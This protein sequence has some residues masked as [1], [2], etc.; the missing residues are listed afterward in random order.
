MSNVDGKCLG[1]IKA[2]TLAQYIAALL[3]ILLHSGRFLEHAESNFFIK[4]IICR[5]AVPLFMVITSYFYRLNHQKS[6]TYSRDYF[7]RQ[8]KTYLF[9]S[10][11]YIPVGCLY[12]WQQGYEWFT[13]PLA[14]LVGFFYLGTWYHLWYIPALLFGIWLTNRVVKRIGYRSSLIL[15][16]CLYVIGSVETYSGYLNHTVIGKIYDVY[17]TMFITTRNGLFFAFIFVLIGFILADFRDHPFISQHAVWKLCLS[18]SF[19]CLEGWLVFQNPGYDKNFMLGLIPVSLFLVASLLK[20]PIG[21][22]KPMNWQFLR[23]QG[24]YLFFLHPIILEILRY[25]ITTING[26]SF[27][28]LPLFLSTILTTTLIIN[29]MLKLKELSIKKGMTF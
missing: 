22:E 19:L 9:W 29:S 27:Q 7:K 13:Y 18:F 28:G 20:S 14:L 4:N 24:K 11:V 17:A 21:Q 25:V 8:L 15:G 5:L 16:I 3:V 23:E 12:L 1:N 2:L 26:G 6:A 10:V